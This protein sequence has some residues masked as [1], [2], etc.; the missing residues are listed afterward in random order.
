MGREQ[1]GGFRRTGLIRVS[2][3]I[4]AIV[5]GLVLT[6]VLDRVAG[7][8]THASSTTGL[9][10]HPHST[11]SYRTTE[12]AF[13]ATTNALGF[14]DHEFAPAGAAACRVVAIGDSFTFGWGVTLEESW[15]KVLESDLRRR[16]LDVDVANLGFPGGSPADYADIA[17]RALPV[18]RPQVVVV[19]VLQG[20]DLSQLRGTS[21]SRSTEYWPQRARHL[22]LNVEETLYPHLVLLVSHALDQ[23]HAASSLTI[24]VTWREQAQAILAKLDPVQRARY[25]RMDSA[26]RR[27][28]EGGDLNPAL[29]QSA[30]RRPETFLEVW[31]IDRPETRSLIATMAS[32]L[33]RIR[34]SADRAWARVVVASIPMGLY[35]DP[36]MF[37]TWRDRYGYELDPRMLTSPAAD[38]AIRLAAQEA[39]L[40]METVTEAFRQHTGRRL[41]FELDGHL[42]SGGH[43][44][45]AERLA[46]AIAAAL[47]AR[48]RS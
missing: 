1:G 19:G 18:L 27:A 22:L 12:F 26:I 20:D 32:H 46:P 37:A 34:T 42:D 6:V 14:R 28:F 23:R 10:F 40:P 36:M 45:Y 15:P 33:R 9:I 7:L 16:G 24:N 2:V 47:P 8:V 48:C 4:I 25:A 21:P 5:A 38:E 13:T 43:R 44:L 30:V 31:E 3:T 11:A 17:S 41:Y 35:V 39:G 29:V